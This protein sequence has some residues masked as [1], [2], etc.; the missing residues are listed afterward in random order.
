[1]D[2]V[3][4]V[5]GWIGTGGL[6]TQLAEPAEFVTLTSCQLG[7]SWIT[8]SVVTGAVVVT[9]ETKSDGTGVYFC[10]LL[11]G[12][13]KMVKFEVTSLLGV[14]YAKVLD[15]G[16]V[17]DDQSHGVD[18]SNTLFATSTKVDLAESEMSGNYGIG[19]RSVQS[20]TC[21][22]VSPVH[23][24]CHTL[25]CTR[26]LRSLSVLL[27]LRDRSE[28]HGCCRNDRTHLQQGVG[29]RVPRG[30]ALAGHVRDRAS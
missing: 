25:H 11:Q 30:P 13:L 10:S 6:G 5:S 9:P 23:G 28:G 18:E 21:V 16:Y 19:A 20:R 15:A 22:C 27:V 2:S 3:S 12:V 14:L 8:G 26:V 29:P 17:D 4:E 1:M 24:V 7:G